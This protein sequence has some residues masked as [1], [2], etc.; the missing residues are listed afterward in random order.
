MWTLALSSVSCVEEDVQINI[1]IKPG[2]VSAL[3][4]KPVLILFSLRVPIFIWL[5][6]SDYFLSSCRL[7]STFKN[8]CFV[9][10][11][12]FYSIFL[13]VLYLVHHTSGNGSWVS[14]ILC[15]GC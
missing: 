4:Q 14:N 13:V 7:T 12:T 15:C 6:V 10:I 8:M 3:R 9:S 1:V 11:V 5:L 2:L